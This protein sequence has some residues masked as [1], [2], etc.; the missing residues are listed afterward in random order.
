MFKPKQILIFLILWLALGFVGRSMMK[1]YDIETYWESLKGY[2]WLDTNERRYNLLILTGPVCYLYSIIY[3]AVQDNP[4]W[5]M[6]FDVKSKKILTFEEAK[7][8][9]QQKQQN[10]K[11]F[12][13]HNKSK[14]DFGLI[15][16]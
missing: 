14:I 13:K 9:K 12:K 2:A 15:Y 5:G 8:L 7:K 10:P 4:K 6:V 16:C 1:Y 11:K 3:I